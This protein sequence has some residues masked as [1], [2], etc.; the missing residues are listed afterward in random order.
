MMVAEARRVRGAMG[1][2]TATSIVVDGDLWS[3]AP[4]DGANVTVVQTKGYSAGEFARERLR[5][6]QDALSDLASE[7]RAV[8]AELRAPGADDDPNRYAHLKEREADVLERMQA[9]E[10]VQADARWAI[11]NAEQYAYRVPVKALLDDPLEV[12]CL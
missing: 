7:L 11:E 2:R 10:A 8:E 12:P 6:A 5:K 3:I 4:Y 9:Q 1:V